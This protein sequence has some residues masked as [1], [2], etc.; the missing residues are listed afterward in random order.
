VHRTITF[1]AVVLASL[2]AGCARDAVRAKVAHALPCPEELATVHERELDDGS[3][4]WDGSG[5]GRR[6]SFTCSRAVART[7]VCVQ[8]AASSAP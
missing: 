7:L 4:V 6:V 2:A 5:C 3:V 1:A 8:D